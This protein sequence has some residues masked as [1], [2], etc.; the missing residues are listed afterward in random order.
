MTSKRPIGLIGAGLMGHGIAS[1]LLKHGHALAVLE[2]PGNQPLDALLAAG[3]TTQRS[4][5][6]LARAV[7]VVILCVTGSPQVEAVLQGPDGVLSGLRPGAVVIDCS[8]AVPQSTARMA[9][10]VHAAGGR[11]LDAPMTR[12]PKEAAEGRLNLLVGG[13]AALFAECRPLLAC[14]AENITHV[15]P[16]GAGH[17]MKLLHN[18][19][20]LGFI[21]LLSEAAACAQRAGVAPTVL[22]DVLAKGGG[23][24][25]A[26]ERLKPF[27]IDRD[28]SSL[29]FAMANAQK[30]IGYYQTMARDAGAVAEI[31]DAV[32]RTYAQAA[33]EGGPQALAIELSAL[34]AARGRAH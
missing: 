29:R 5:Q 1:N 33:A 31:A 22:V 2:H 20:S 12:T 17:S 26:L 19:V 11:F 14:F 10:A 4:A 34:L 32:L 7:D 24:S 16:V 25:V 6:A 30:D 13:D 27:L 3:A 15:G 9:Q 28:T 23:G 8:T 21:A 18:Y